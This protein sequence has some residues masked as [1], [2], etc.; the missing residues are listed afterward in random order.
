MKFNF[1]EPHSS[2][3]IYRL[4]QLQKVLLY[5]YLYEYIIYAQRIYTNYFKFTNAPVIICRFLVDIEY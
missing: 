3:S 2:T 4:Y 1:M 5:I